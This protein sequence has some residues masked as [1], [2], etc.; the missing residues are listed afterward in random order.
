MFSVLQ[1]VIL[2]V[3]PYLCCKLSSIFLQT[4]TYFLAK[5]HLANCAF[6]FQCWVVKYSLITL[7][8]RVDLRSFTLVR[9]YFNEISSEEVSR[10]LN[11]SH[12]ILFHVFQGFPSNHMSCHMSYGILG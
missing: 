2:K 7:G 4:V 9:A 5:Y 12:Y 1:I 3:V 11:F 6:S 8:A 10:D